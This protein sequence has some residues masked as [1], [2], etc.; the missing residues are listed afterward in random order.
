[1]RRL[2]RLFAVIC[3]MALST[4]GLITAPVLATQATDEVTSAGLVSGQWRILV[5]Q[6]VVG[7]ELPMFGLGANPDGQWVVVIAD[8]TNLGATTIFDPA[9]IS[10]GVTTD[11]PLSMTDGV[12]ADPA[13]TVSAS[14]N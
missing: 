4:S 7:S 3:I 8:V 14:Q 13:R 5:H 9:T 1:M 6:T 12:A 11:S 10:I 2:Y